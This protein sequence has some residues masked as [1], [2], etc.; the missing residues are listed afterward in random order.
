MTLSEALTR[1]NT[2][3]SWSLSVNEHNAYY[4]TVA[5]FLVSREGALSSSAEEEARIRA[6]I[7]NDHCA[8]VQV[9]PKTPVG[10]FVVIDANVEAALIR[11]AAEMSK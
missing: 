10:F 4:E 11:A 2:A 6:C 3:N 5:A 7:D 1:L 9:Y 8:W